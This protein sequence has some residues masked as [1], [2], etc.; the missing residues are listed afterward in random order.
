[1]NTKTR[2]NP[3]T[4]K[5]LGA[6]NFRDIGGVKTISGQSVCRS[7][8]FRSERLSSLIEEDIKQLED[9]NISHVVD[10][11]SE[12][13]RK[14]FP[15]KLPKFPPIKTLNL[16]ILTDVRSSK[17]NVFEPLRLD[18]S[19]RGAQTVMTNLYRNMPK[20]FAPHL[21]ILVSTILTSNSTSIIHCTAGKDR[22]G[23]VS[24][25]ILHMLGVSSEFY[26]EDYMNT[27]IY[28]DEDKWHESIERL[29]T[30]QIGKAPHSSVT[31][32]VLDV[33]EEYIDAAFENIILEYESFENYI[34]KGCGINNA[35]IDNLRKSFLC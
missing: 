6:P 4:L 33:K 32:E 27:K 26:K 7:R 25:V 19:I 8:L 13:E 17:S 23:F 16:N 3:S 34:S 35:T 11:R 30:I 1:M 24:S 28:F 5:L 14:L 12:S 20:A 22:T 2:D 9:L 31:K 10:L 21:K 18:P 15:N 29:L